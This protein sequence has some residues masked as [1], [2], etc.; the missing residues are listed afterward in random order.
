MKKS[1]LALA[2]V[3]AVSGMAWGQWVFD[4]QDGVQSIE[5]RYS[6]GRFTSDVDDYMDPAFFDANIG[7]FMFLGGY[8]DTDGLA[9]EVPNGTISVGFGKTLGKGMYLGLF[10]ATQTLSA[11]GT[12][13][14]GGTK[15]HD[16]TDNSKNVNTSE[17]TWNNK[18][19]ALFGVAGMGFRLDLDMF[20]EDG[21]PTE[22]KMTTIDGK[23]STQ[24]ITNGPALGLTWGTLLMNDRLA[25]YVSLGYRF[26]NI[27]TRTELTPQ[28]PGSDPN[29]PYT[30][31]VDKSATYSSDAQFKISAAAWYKLAEDK[32]VLAELGFTAKIP[33]SYKGDKEA[34]AKFSNY[35]AGGTENPDGDKAYTEDGGFD[36]GLYAHFQKVLTFG[37]ATVKVVPWLD[38]GLK[39][40]DH[41]TS[42]DEK[43]SP[44]DNEFNLTTGL[45]IGAEYKHDKIGLYTGAGI[46]FFDWTVNSMSGGDSDF[47]NK[48]YTWTFTGIQWDDNRIATTG[49][50]NFGLTFTPIEGLVFGTGL[51]AIIPSVNLKT[52]QIAAPSSTNYGSETMITNILGNSAMSVTV[53]YKF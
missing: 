48:D 43:K 37:E 51:S 12:H 52:M 14:D 34:L 10:Y 40:D 50:L 13:K 20:D 46:Q 42:L 35:Q 25:P 1:I 18:V 17:V 11:F 28:E 24:T 47:T 5:S 27:D 9:A 33:N 44:S 7:T 8:G 3:L 30:Q 49:V 38:L 39:V 21:N 26:P 29:D 15:T 32:S 45:K 41:G 53:S 23:V 16:N 19:A 36:L 4:A 22:D 2:V 31:T 6:A